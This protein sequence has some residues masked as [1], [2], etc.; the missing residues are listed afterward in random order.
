MRFL[1]AA[2]LTIG[3]FTI[4]TA[5]P[6][7]RGKRP[8]YTDIAGRSRFSY[9]TNN[10]FTGRK[11]FPQP[12]CGGVA[13]F[14]YDNDGWLDIFFTNGASFPDLKKTNSSF[15]NTLLHNR[16]D[17]TF[18]DV[19]VDSGLAGEHLGYSLGAAAGDYDNDGWTD[20]FI[21][22]AGGNTLYRNNGD[23]TFRD[24]TAESGLGATPAGTLSV[25][26]AWFDYDNDGRLDLILSNYTVWTAETDRRCVRTDGVDFY[27]HPRT[28]PA[29][30][31]RLYRNLGGSK[32]QDVTE[33]SGIAKVSGKGMGIGIADVNGD[34]WMDVFV[35]NDTERNF[36]YMNQK[37]GTFKEQG[38]L[39]GVAYNDEGTTVSAMGADVKD[40][41]N[42]GWPDVFYNDLAGQIW[43][44]FHNAAGRSFRYASPAARMVSLSERYSGWSAGFIDYNNDG[45]KD[46]FSANGDVDN[47]RA[48]AEQ[49]DTMFE[50]VNGKEFTDVSSQMGEDFL[51]EGYQR[52]S[53]FADLNNDGFLDIVVTSLH[54]RPRILI[55]SGDN[56]AH[57]LLI[58]AR[59]RK[60][61]RDAIGAKIKVTTR[62]GRTLYNHVTTS[63][64]FLSS[65][66]RRV[67]FGLGAETSA[68][69]IE[70]RWPSGAVDVRRNVAADQIL[71]VQEP[72]VP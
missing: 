25:Q 48:G 21:A 47:L 34:G 70:I 14:D 68:A 71:A 4:P 31:H 39:L 20:L 53:A 66:D 22:N 64:G 54:R 61:N 33:A 42:D 62:S 63:V 60:S 19:S 30:P 41:D 9:I 29:V 24:V 16:H 50:N 69:S 17:G 32:F 8:H 57:W 27:C 1:L 10:G 58:A 45:W 11:Y 6:Q 7:A 36:L 40:Y 28:Y 56:G 18:E 43:G 12:L 65:S 13:A 23:G 44:L 35:A 52:G 26:A 46:L 51:R 5:R 38:L 67:H 37:D 59:G 72:D 2:V 3:C 55:N 15:Y 49:H